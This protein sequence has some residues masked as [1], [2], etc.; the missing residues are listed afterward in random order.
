MEND[1]W[2]AG[3]LTSTGSGESE[4]NKTFECVFVCIFS[5]KTEAK[6]EAEE[7]EEE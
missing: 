2:L 7:E 6:E 3:V 5:S 4:A 1:V